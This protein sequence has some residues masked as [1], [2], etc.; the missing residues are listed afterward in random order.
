[1]DV[2]DSCG[3]LALGGECTNLHCEPSKIKRSKDR[4]SRV[5]KQKSN[6]SKKN[7]KKKL[8]GN[9][10]RH[11]QTDGSILIPTNIH[12]RGEDSLPKFF[13]Y[14]T[15]KTSTSEQRKV[16]L[17]KLFEAKLVTSQDALNSNSIAEFGSASSQTRKKKII[18]WFGGR[19]YRSNSPNLKESRRK[20]IDDKEY[21]TKNF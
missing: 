1:M 20:L 16:A 11:I 7:N 19:V 6:I 5:K 8:K 12:L 2:C 3:S 18:S 13:G 21:V 15:D 10:N 9:F 14:K 17:S 4:A